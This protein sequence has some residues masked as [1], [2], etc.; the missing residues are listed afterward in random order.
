[1]WP[2]RT[3]TVPDP[4]S[5]DTPTIDLEKG[6]AGVPRPRTRR[7]A[8]RLRMAMDAA[9][10][11]F[12]ITDAGGRVELMNRA[13]AELLGV[14]ARA[15]LGRHL[16]AL[17][18]GQCAAPLAPR[19]EDGSTAAHVHHL[20][21]GG[22]E[23][24]VDH[25]VTI[26]PGGLGVPAMSVHGLSDRTSAQRHLAILSHDES[27]DAVTGLANLHGLMRWLGHE[28]AVAASP[29]GAGLPAYYGLIVC[30]IDAFGAWNARLGATAADEMLAVVGHRIRSLVR[31]RDFVARSGADEFAVVL[32]GVGLWEARAVGAKILAAHAEP[33]S[34][35]TA[36]PRR[37]EVS[38]SLTASRESMLADPEVAILRARRDLRSTRRPGPD[39]AARGQ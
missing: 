9:P 12:A 28:R 1:M 5:V 11:G 17:L 38:L 4:P 3:G 8:D 39:D 37:V 33:L 21:G 31:S 14:D 16:S 23:R 15:V 20:R 36:R 18:P 13:M 26:I 32:R 34:V 30:D 6:S 10:L 25:T 19:R 35:G 2:S 29:E 7:R 24:W 27:R 22:V